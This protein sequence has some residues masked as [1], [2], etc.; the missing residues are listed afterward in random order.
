MSD[1]EPSTDSRENRVGRALHV[2]VLTAAAVSVPAVFLARLDGPVGTAGSVL[3]W[4]SMLVLTTESV[5]LFWASENRLRWLRTH[6]WMVLVSLLTIPAV[7]FA[8]GPAQVLRLVRLV[9]AVQLVRV[10][11]LVKVARLVHERVG[12]LGAARYVLLAGVLVAAAVLLVIVLAD[13]TSLT[14]RTLDAVVQRW[15]WP[16][17]LGALLLFVTAIGGAVTWLRRRRVD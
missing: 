13:E 12:A 3:N 14:R 4:L 2:P 17:L 9:A 10:V 1:G 16:T 5:L 15:G 6:W 11:R 7:V 8:F